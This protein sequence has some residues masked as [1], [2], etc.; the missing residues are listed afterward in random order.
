MVS[1]VLICL[2]KRAEDSFLRR[3]AYFKFMFDWMR[4]GYTPIFEYVGPTN[5]IV[6]R[7]DTH[8]LVLLALRH[9]AT[10]EYLS[11]SAIK[12]H[13]NSHGIEVAATAEG[14]D[15]VKNVEHFIDHTSNL[16]DLEG[17]VVAFDHGLR[18]KIKAH[19]YLTKH[20]ALD[21]MSSKKKVVALCV[22]G[23]ADDIMPVLDEADRNE[24]ARFRH[25]LNILAER[26]CNI[27]LSR[28]DFAIAIIDDPLNQ[29]PDWIKGVCFGLLDGKPARPSVLKNMQKNWD[30]LP[31]TWR[32]V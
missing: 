6:L 2:A 25:N 26:Y 16:I 28:K 32:G 17:Y 9:N 3:P 12:A 8:R 31:V 18:V 24:L 21:D 5:R 13:A 30:T 7:Y 19:E 29:I 20:R 22:Q 1:G 14:F 27:V 11:Y 4:N 15:S 23:F 10:G